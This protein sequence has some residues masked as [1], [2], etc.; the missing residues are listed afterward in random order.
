MIWSKKNLTLKNGDNMEQKLKKIFLITSKDRKP[1]HIENLKVRYKNQ[2]YFTDHLEDSD[3]VLCIGM[4]DVNLK[5]DMNV[6]MAKE[7]GIRISYFTDDF[8]PD[9][10]LDQELDK[11][12]NHNTKF[13]EISFLGEGL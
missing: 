11:L 10:K 12:E 5:N 4:K 3:M 9:W 13:D 7:M 2:V 8:L 1:Y 6:L